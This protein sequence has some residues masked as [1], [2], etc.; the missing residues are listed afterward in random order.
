MKKN[1]KGQAVIESIIAI[2]L[3]LIVFVVLLP[4][5]GKFV[6]SKQAT[7]QAAR[8]M[9]WERTVWFENTP[10]NVRHAA[11]KSNQQLENEIHWRFYSN[12][13]AQ[14]SSDDANAD[15]EWRVANNLNPMLGTRNSHTN[16]LVALIEPQ[17]EVNNERR[18]KLVSATT[19]DNDPGGA[20]AAINRFVSL[21][22]FGG[23]AVNTKGLKGSKVSYDFAS[24]P[25]IEPFDEEFNLDL[26]SELFVQADGWNTAGR[27]HT[28]KNVQGLTPSSI[29][30]FD[31]MKTI[32]RGIGG[33]FFAKELKPTSLIF[34]HV[35]TEAVPEQRLCQ[36]RGNRCRRNR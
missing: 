14:L 6:E 5:L 30:N 27:E 33:M 11:V 8:Y 16:G 32:Q 2:S 20:S 35:D 19:S 7:D 10:N 15:K 36:L 29:L 31:F 23:F 26:E 9:A 21:I 1:C 4:I 18:D 24:L 12:N 13:Q 25:G 28:I 3:V 17:Q 34:G 22:D